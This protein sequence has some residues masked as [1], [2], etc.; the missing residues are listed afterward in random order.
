M[1][2]DTRF[3]RLPN[4]EHDVKYDRFPVNYDK[5]AGFSRAFVRITAF[6]G[7]VLF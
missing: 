5:I 7:S 3:E 2:R 1:T 4:A 6:P